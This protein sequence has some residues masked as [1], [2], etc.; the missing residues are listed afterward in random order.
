MAKVHGLLE[1]Y[2]KLDSSHILYTP[3]PTER[4]ELAVLTDLNEQIK[5]INVAYIPASRLL[6]YRRIG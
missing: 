2:H 4:G 6:G 5:A 3:T 1:E